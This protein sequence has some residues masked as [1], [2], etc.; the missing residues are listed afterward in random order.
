MI[1]MFAHLGVFIGGIGLFLLGM[2]LMTDGLKFAAGN[3]LRHLLAH[4]TQTPVRG[5]LTGI[6][7]TTAVQSSSAVTVASIGFVNAGLLTLTQAIWVIFGSNIGTTMTGW[8]VAITGMQLKLDAYALPLIG[9]GMLIRL[10][11]TASKRAALGQAL[12]G[13]AVFL[14]GIQALKSGFSE[15]AGQVDFTALPSSGISSGLVYFGIGVILTFLIQSSSATTAITI[16]AASAGIIPVPLAA[17]IIIGADLGTSSTAALAA[18]GATANARRAA[19]SHVLLNLVTT[20][21]AITFLTVL[22]TGVVLL[23]DLLHLPDDPGIT[24]ALFSTVFNILGVMLMLPF[25]A[26]VVRWLEQRFVSREEDTARPRHLDSNLLAVPTL[27]LRG[28]VLELQRMG[29][30][31]LSILAESINAKD[32]EMHLL[33]QRRVAI[34][35]LGEHIRNYVGQMNRESL[36]A[37]I[38]EALAPSLRALQNYDESV[39]IALSMT[40]PDKQIST[41]YTALFQLYTQSLRVALAA[42]DTTSIEFNLENLE[43]AEIDVKQCYQLL[44]KQ[45]LE[46][47]ASGHLSVSTMDIHMQNIVRLD[48]ALER[49]IKAARRLAPLR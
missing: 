41:K 24:L 13:F 45:L 12:V 35:L 1:N 11:G 5:L 33:R 16:T 23:R 36:P 22:L 46:A 19:T 4:S 18:I 14:L 3:T 6:G 25:T 49:V 40:S 28:L 27:A 15:L 34:D 48:R 44:K 37:D 10:T 26:A 8:I 47:A 7:L 39:D 9:I 43:H 21:F 29:T 42:A 31:A 20:A 30:L 38:A 32:V 2:W 17:L